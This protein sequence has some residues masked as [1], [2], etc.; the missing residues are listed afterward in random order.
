[1]NHL[2][3]TR[4]VRT[5]MTLRGR[6]TSFSLEAGVWDALTEMCRQREQSLDEM[7]EQIVAEAEPGMSMASAD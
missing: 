7:C 5:N 1:M 3:P 4:Q 6:R 2:D